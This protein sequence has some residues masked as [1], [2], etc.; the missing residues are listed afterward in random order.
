M[1]AIAATALYMLEIDLSETRDGSILL[2]HDDD[3]DRTT[4]GHGPIAALTVAE[5]KKLRLKDSPEPLPRFDA[6]ARWAAR[7]RGVTLMLDIKKTPPAKIAPIVKSA[8]ITDRVLVLTFDRAT[9]QSA[10]A[11]DPHWRIS[12][13][14]RSSEELRAYRDLFAGRPFVAYLPTVSPT[15]LFAEARAAGVTILTDVMSG[16]ASSPDTRAASDAEAYRNYLADHPADLLVTDH[17]RRMRACAG[18]NSK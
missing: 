14:V 15:A 16:G 17:A 8:H 2:L 11:T 7:T 1:K 4:T 10:I 9:T 6:V 3:L 13:L 12:A 18:S 5:V